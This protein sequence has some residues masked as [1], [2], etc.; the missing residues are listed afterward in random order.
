MSIMPYTAFR[1]RAAT[2]ILSALFL[3]ILPGG[4]VRGPT[5]IPVNQRRVIDRQLVDYPGGVVMKEVMR[6]IT[7]PV[8]IEIDDDD[9]LIIAEGGL[10]DGDPHIYGYRRGREDGYFSIY[11][12]GKRLPLNIQNIAGGFRIYGPIGG[13]TLDRQSKKLYV[14]HRNAQGDGVITAF[15][16]DGSHTTVDAGFPAKGDFSITDIA[17]SP[18]TG[19]LWF[20][21]GAATNSGVVGLDNWRWAKQNPNFCDQPS[22]PLKLNGYHFMSKN[23]DAGLLGGADIS[24]TG[25]FQPF[26][27][28]TKSVIPAARNGTPTAAVYSCN[29]QGGGRRVE[30]WG[31]RC[32]R[33]IAF[34]EYGQQFAT[35]D[36]M[37]LRGT[38]PVKNDPDVLLRLVSGTWLGWPDFSAD[39]RPISD[40]VFQPPPEMARRYGYS[41]VSALIDHRASNNGDGLAVTPDMRNTLVQGVF[42]S[43][44]G[45]AK[46]D[47]VPNNGPLRQWRG[48]AI[49]ALS[50]DRA[51]FATSGVKNF[52]GPVGFKVVRVDLI[53]RTVEDIVRN[54]KGGPASRLPSS[55]GLLERPVAVKFAPSGALYIVDIG[56]MDFKNGRERVKPNT[57]RIFIIEPLQSPDPLTPTT[58]PNKR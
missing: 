20:G 23:P 29:P 42:P 55:Q 7:G 16:M 41:D 6:G 45:A 33:G 11:P 34:N 12:A 1:N 28:S 2:L 9:T 19:R 3:V 37:E 51:P 17:I 58:L 44:S 4:C 39:L 52:L 35:N 27:E 25:P 36:G 49:V 10:D 57:G 56:E 18:T 40:A 43:L 30:V 5:F 32:P 31:I 15:G 14:T 21:V 13:M 54:T 26:G 46:L 47:F 24:V 8:A 48:N 50:G 22:V 38:R 53:N